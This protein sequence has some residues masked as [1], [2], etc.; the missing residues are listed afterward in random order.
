M[1]RPSASSSRKRSIES[2]TPASIGGILYVSVVASVLAY[3]AWNRG[4]ARIGP[5]R[6]GP[7]MYLMLLYTPI[8][9]IAFLGERVQLYHFA[10]AALIV[11]GI[12]LATVRGRRGG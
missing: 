10:G 8:L 6:A 2:V 5:A 1:T 9:S 7:F 3:V 4:V 11:A 12:Y